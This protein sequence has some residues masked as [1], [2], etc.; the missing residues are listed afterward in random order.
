MTYYAHTQTP[1]GKLL[2]VSDGTYVTRVSMPLQNNAPSVKDDWVMSTD[3][4]PIKL[5]IEQFK[6]YFAGLLDHFDLPIIF[7]GTDFQNKVWHQL[8]KI[9]YGK[10]ISY[11]ELARRVGN[12]NA[13]RAVG[14]ANGKNPLAIIVPCH[15]VVAGDGSLGGYAGGVERKQQLLALEQAVFN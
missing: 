13:S 8:T 11:G 9:P 12:P 2:V 3:I 6:S 1:I 14:M 15:R 7:H 4:P 5:A 10:T